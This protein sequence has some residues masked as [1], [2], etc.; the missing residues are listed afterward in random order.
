MEAD[1]MLCHVI[2]VSE[3]ISYLTSWTVLVLSYIV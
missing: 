1:V 2:V 3:D